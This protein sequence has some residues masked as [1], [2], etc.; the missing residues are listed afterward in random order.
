[1]D[2]KQNQA[3]RRQNRDGG[4]PN[5][6][7]FYNIVVVAPNG[8]TIDESN[9][10]KVAGNKEGGDL[11]K[12]LKGEGWTPVRVFNEEAY[13]KARAEFRDT[14]KRSTQESRDTIIKQAFADAEVEF[15]PRVESA[16]RILLQVMDPSE[17]RTAT[18]LRNVARAADSAMTDEAREKGRGKAKA[19][20][21]DQQKQAASD[22]HDDGG[23]KQ[24]P[25]S[26]QEEQSENVA[27]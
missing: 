4:K 13:E 16:L 22:S 15:N 10:K 25:Q 3:D 26:D 21:N 23:D 8:T 2:N 27:H 17:K 6:R 19:K 18:A 20:V 12:A 5:K 11:R 24:N 7:D 14:H 9:W 1:M